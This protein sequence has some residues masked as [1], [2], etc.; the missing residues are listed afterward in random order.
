L[1]N[2]DLDKLI[3]ILKSEY[4]LYQNIYNL[5][6]TKKEV[7]INRDIDQLREIVKK[8]ETYLTKTAKLEEKRIEICKENSLTEI[9]K[10][11]NA[12]YRTELN[13]IRDNLVT[14]FEDLK[15]INSLNKELL[16]ISLNL[17]N[18]TM[19]F[20]NSNNRRSTYGKKGM[21]S[22]NKDQHKLINHKA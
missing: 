10:T 2:I 17:N 21:V 15:N 12:P 18:M 13:L 11:V 19:A 14:L 5:A 8:E 16:D 22:S 20:L 7:I 3:S 1:F 4:E 9:L 6:K